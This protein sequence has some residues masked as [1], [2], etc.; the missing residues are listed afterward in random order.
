MALVRLAPVLEGNDRQTVFRYTEQL[1]PV[2]AN[3]A[4]TI[5]NAW[6][7]VLLVP[8]LAWLRRPIIGAGAGVALVCLLLI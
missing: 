7:A 5:A 8:V 2:V 4:L 3:N 6:M 1:Q